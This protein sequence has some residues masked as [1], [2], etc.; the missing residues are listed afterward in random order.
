MV[1]DIHGSFETMIRMF[2]GAVG[3]EP[4][5]FPGQQADGSRNIYL[6]NGDYVDRGFSGYQVVFTLAL[7]TL[8]FPECVYV[9]RGNHESED[10]GLN[11][12]RF[13][14]NGFMKEMEKKFP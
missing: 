8:S 1:G 10:L 4:I 13:G 11:A 9:N 5:G 12:T 2:K 3:V 7:L 14:D 6:F